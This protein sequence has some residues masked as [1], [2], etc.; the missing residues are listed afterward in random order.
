M[1]EA[2]Y[3][4]KGRT[5]KLDSNIEQNGIRVEV[6]RYTHLDKTR[7]RKGNIHLRD[8]YLQQ[9]MVSTIGVA[10]LTRR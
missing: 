5:R 7:A 10:F 4:K 2:L 1:L 6:S 9:L 8:M 3:R